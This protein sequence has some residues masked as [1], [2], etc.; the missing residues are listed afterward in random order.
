VIK[1]FV[2]SKE[3]THFPDKRSVTK[4]VITLQEE[5]QQEQTITD[6]VIM[7][8]NRGKNVEAWSH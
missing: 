2:I 4:K 6:Y 5:E 7:I 3:L 1:L 8:I